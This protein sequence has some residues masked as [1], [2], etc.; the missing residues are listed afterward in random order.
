MAR[1]R[2]GRAIPLYQEKKLLK[3]RHK[4]YPSPLIF[5][6]NGDVARFE[7]YEFE[8]TDKKVID[9]LKKNPDIEPAKKPAQKNSSSETESD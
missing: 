4:T 3:L 9:E 1:F 7:D 8:T 5:L 2:R 6:S